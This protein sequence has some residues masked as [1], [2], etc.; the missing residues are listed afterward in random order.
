MIVGA[1]SYEGL[2]RGCHNT[3]ATRTEETAGLFRQSDLLAQ[4]F[5]ARVRSQEGKFGAVQREAHPHGTDSSPPLQLLD[6]VV[7]VSEPGEK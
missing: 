4:R 7:F 1:G 6:C 3:A 2:R 5:H